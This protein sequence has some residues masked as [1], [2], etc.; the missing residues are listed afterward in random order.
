MS[1]SAPAS[2]SPSA[3]AGRPPRRATSGSSSL[4]SI[5][6]RARARPR[7]SSSASSFEADEAADRRQRARRPRHRLR[8]AR[9]ASIR[10]TN[11]PQPWALV[12]GVATMARRRHRRARA[13]RALPRPRGLGLAGAPRGRWSSPHSAARAGRSTTGRAAR[14]STRRSS[15]CSLIAVGGGVGTVMAATSSNPAPASGRTYLVNGHRLYL[16]CVGSG[17]RLSSSSTGSANGRPAGRGCRRTCR[18]R[19]ASARSIAPEKAGAAGRR[20]A[21]TA[22]SW[23]PTCTRFLHAAHVPGPYVLAGHSVGGTYALVYADAV[24]EPGRRSRA[25]RLG[26]AV[27]VRP[28]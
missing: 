12:P 22:I 23:P 1:R 26:D 6:G 16:N 17:S 28:S 7:C 25:H 11:Q 2:T 20:F 24:P 14:S 21:Q 8:L 5:A 13:W 9:L 19:R 3:T 10:F 15:C 4:A 18:P 27:S